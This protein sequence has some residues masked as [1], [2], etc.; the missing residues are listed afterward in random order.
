M[1]RGLLT[2]LVLGNLSLAHGQVDSEYRKVAMERAKKIVEKVEPALATDKR[3]KTRDLVADQYIALNNIHAERDRKL[4]DAG[5]AKE[6]VLADA[7]AAIAAQHRQYIQSLGALITAEQIEEIKDGMTYHTVPK[8]YNN[9]KLMLPFA[10]DEELSMIH[11]NLTEAREYAMDGGSAKEKHAW[12]NKYKGRIANQLASCGYNLK[13]EGEEW[14]ERRSLESTA[15]CIAESNR[16]MQ[17]LTLSDEWQAEQV[18][19]LLAYQYQ[20]MD[21]IYAKKKS[22]TTTMEQASLDGTAKEDRAMAIWKESKAALDTQRD[23]LF[24]KLALLLTETQIELVKDEMTYNGFQKELS[25]FEELLPQLTDEHK[26]AIIEY[27][28]EARENA[29]NVLTNRERNQWFTKYRGRA[30]NYLSKQGYDLRKATEDLERRTKER[31][32]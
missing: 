8:T 19:N 23:K 5:A 27:L 18:R 25:R 31:R 13:K 9:Y 2:F 7:D 24:E 15:Y 1:K 12:F 29:L 4:G 10:S 28:K 16:L 11:K 26:A 14:A 17:T 20:K 21:E 30:N 22:E 3:N 6:Q 32:K